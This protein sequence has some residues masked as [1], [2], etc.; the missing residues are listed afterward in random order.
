MKHDWLLEVLRDIEDYAMVNQM[1]WLVPLANKVN[2]IA[3]SELIKGDTRTIRVKR[4]QGRSGGANRAE[5]MPSKQLSVSAFQ[6]DL[7]PSF[8]DASF[9]NF[10]SPLA[11]LLW[12]KR[13]AAALDE[14]T[15]A[16]TVWKFTPAALTQIS[17]ISDGQAGFMGDQI[18]REKE[19]PRLFGCP[20]ELVAHSSSFD[21]CFAFFDAKSQ[22]EHWRSFDAFR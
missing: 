8:D 17:M 10:A 1:D 20:I 7:V 5:G 15:K 16:R 22:E 11:A 21:C 19:A 4:V 18:F 13:M 6:L 14:E 9:Q 12:I 2:A 3:R